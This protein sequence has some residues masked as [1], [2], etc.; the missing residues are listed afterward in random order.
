MAVEDARVSEQAH[1]ATVAMWTRG[2]FSLHVDA[3]LTAPWT[4][5]FGPSGAGKS[6]LLRLIAGLTR[7]DRGWVLLGGKSLECE[8]L[9]WSASGRPCFLT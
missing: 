5:L 6:S 4:V 8:A 7:P 2:S 1:L 3:K 9:D